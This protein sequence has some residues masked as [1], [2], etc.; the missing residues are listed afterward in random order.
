MQLRFGSQAALLLNRGAATAE[1]SFSPRRDLQAPMDRF[2]VRDL[3]QHRDLGVY[4]IPVTV[5][6]Q[7]HEARVFRIRQLATSANGRSADAQTPA[8]AR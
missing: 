6:V 5:E 8:A 1:M 3:W 2:S 7:S 4:D